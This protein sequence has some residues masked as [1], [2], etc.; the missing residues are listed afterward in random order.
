LFLDR[1]DLK[2]LVL[3]GRAQ[4]VI[5]DLEL[6]DGKGEEVDLLQRLDLTVSDQSTQLG[7]WYPF[8]IPFLSGTPTTSTPTTATTY[9]QTNVT[10]T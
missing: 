6:F 1:H 8:L 7:H 10:T 3:E 4:E 2:Y 5:D 9:T